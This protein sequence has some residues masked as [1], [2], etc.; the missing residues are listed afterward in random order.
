VQF[1]D[2]IREVQHLYKE[3]QWQFQYLVCTGCCWYCWCSLTSV[4]LYPALN[5]LLYLLQQV[6]RHDVSMVAYL[7]VAAFLGYRHA[8][9][10]LFRSSSVI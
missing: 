3:W 2:R 8:T 9:I 10:V 6:Q 7:A 5:R 4:I 1:I